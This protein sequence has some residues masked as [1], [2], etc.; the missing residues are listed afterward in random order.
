MAFYLSPL[1][2]VR[3]ID[4]T[5]TI[6]AVGTSIAC[7]VLRK[8]YKGDELKKTLITT[9]E[10][11]LSA[12]GEPNDDCFKDM[13]SAIGYLKYGNKLYCSRA[14]P[15]TSTF[16]GTYGSVG[17]S[18]TSDSTFTAYTSSNAY[19]MLSFTENDPD[20]FDDE[21]IFATSPASGG[22]IAF[23]AR[24]RGTW[25]NYTKVAIIDKV[26]YDNV[27]TYAAG[28][29]T[30]NY[31][32]YVAGA[33]TAG[34]TAMSEELYRDV[35]SI[36]YPVETQ[37][38][39]I[40]L[41]KVAEQDALNQSTI[42]YNL[43]EVFY[44]ST[45]ESKV[46]DIGK[47]IHAPNVINQESKYIRI[48]LTS[49]VKNSDFYCSTDDGV[50]IDY[51]QFA[52]GVNNYTDWDVNSDLEDTEVINGYDLYQNPEEVDVNIFIDSDK[53]LAVKNRLIEICEGSSSSGEQGR[54]D[55]MAL[56]DC[57]YV[58]VVNNSGNET[59][60]L[61]DY[62][63]VTLN[64][65]TSYAAFYGNWLEV[66]DKWNS[67]YRWV[68]ASGYV[69]GIYAKTD[70][71]SD[72]WFAP[73]GLNRSII[74]N[75]RKLAW[76]PTLGNR[77]IMYKN[78]INPIATFA[79][80][81]KVLWGQKT[82]LDKESAFNRINVRRLFM[83]MEKAISTSAKYFLFEPNDEFTR[84]SIVNML[85]PYLRDVRGRRGIYDFLVVCD[86]RNN[87]TERID[88]SELW[89]DIYIKATRSA[90]FIVLNFIATKTG[91]SFTELVAST[92]E[93]L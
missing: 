75:V 59:E 77:D 93:G 45:D 9:L 34:L 70:D 55:A 16:A 20:K 35:L 85:E 58:D 29:S 73:A 64:A 10:E 12:F 23:I 37:R 79:G 40:V 22:N 82:L 14:M 53:N 90:E 26:S 48:A 24:S 72:P 11:L 91:A 41:V 25:G 80:Q 2:D 62:R 49:D 88:R 84:L 47:N 51:I 86:E 39:F 42:T 87:T 83:V 65:N 28:K 92:T 13:F 50:D 66:F 60:A 69:A 38:E 15:T 6:P 57:R 4:L 68:P 81:G 19:T 63:N 52:G 3:E 71:V 31:A 76:S 27:T 89:T 30:T 33:G 46:D 17:T 43:K 7:L 44:C 56:L 78:G 18:G 67:K 32:T 54:L 61:R 74:T 5:T 1:V 8:T 36:D 21:N